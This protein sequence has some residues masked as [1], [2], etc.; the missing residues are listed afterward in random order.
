MKPALLFLVEILAAVGSLA[1]GRPR[2]QAAADRPDGH[3]LRGGLRRPADA[4]DRHRLAVDQ[5]AV[6][7][8]QPVLGRPRRGQPGR[9]TACCSSASACC[10]TRPASCGRRNG[11]TRASPPRAWAASSTTSSTS[12]W[13]MALLSSPD[14]PDA[15]GWSEAWARGRPLE[16]LRQHRDRLSRRARRPRPATRAPGRPPCPRP[17]AADWRPL[18]IDQCIRRLLVVVR[19]W[20]PVISTS[21][22]GTRVLVAI[23]ELRKDLVELDAHLGDDRQVVEALLVSLRARARLLAY[24]LELKS[25]ADPLRPEVLDTLHPAAGHA[26]VAGVGGRPVRARPVRRRVDQGPP[27]RD[28][29]AQPR[30]VT[31][32]L[33]AGRPGGSS[34][35]CPYAGQRRRLAQQPG[36]PGGLVRPA[37]RGPRRAPPRGPARAV[38]RGRPAT[39]RALCAAANSRTAVSAWPSAAARQPP[40]RRH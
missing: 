27:D 37:R 39:P 12:R 1:A 11:S 34:S 15:H 38:P 18:L 2:P 32:L 20:T 36:P 5:L 30:V 33:G 13:A 23:A 35:S 19:D 10:S 24:F 16:W 28:R 7:G 8:D 25:G 17:R 29:G 40:T 26:G 4:A 14:P 3:H 21:R 9:C 31:G 6:A 22:N